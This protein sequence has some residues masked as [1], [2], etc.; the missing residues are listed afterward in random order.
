M[1]DK[2][3]K[4]L[5]KNVTDACKFLKDL[6]VPLS[7]PVIQ[8]PRS[9]DYLYFYQQ[10]VSKSSPV[11]ILNCIKSWGAWKL[12]NEGYLLDKLGD[13]PVTVSITPNG[14]ADAVID[15][16][17]T[18]PHEEVMPFKT[19]ITELQSPNDN[20]VLYLQKQNS[21]FLSEF[22]CLQN[23][24]DT[25]LKWARDIFGTDLDAIN[26]WMG[27]GRA[28]T[29]L[30]KDPYE[31]IYCVVRGSK[32]FTLYPPIDRINF[33]YHNYST[34]K[35][36]SN[37]ILQEFGDIS[38]PWI[39]IDQRDP[40][41]DSSSGATPVIVTVSAG[42]TLYLPSYWFHH[43]TQT[44]GTIAVNFWF[45][46]DYGPNFGTYHLVDEIMKQTE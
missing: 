32:T 13:K 30:H 16:K 45:D 42:E 14:L 26:F 38:T 20:R 43:V 11:K 29:S 46:I 3:A 15:G 24:I 23:D 34:W 36:D 5:K 33:A 1:K 22:S 18:L 6:Y 12:W 25:N 44:H 17:F 31:N 41:N 19:F 37:L 4:L 40:A 28:V 9:E 27:D 35:Y 2:E 7:C 21:S 8:K 39:K 10:F